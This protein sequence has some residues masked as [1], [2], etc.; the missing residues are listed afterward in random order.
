M[1]GGEIIKQKSG[2]PTKGIYWFLAF[3]S[4]EG[5]KALGFINAQVDAGVEPK[6][7]FWGRIS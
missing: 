4:T 3:N 2:H 7:T 6:T 5:V 1:Q